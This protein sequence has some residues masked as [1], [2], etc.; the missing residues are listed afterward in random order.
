M[1]NRESETECG[2]SC[3]SSTPFLDPHG[4]IEQHKS[5][6][7]HWQQGEV[8]YFVTWRLADALPQEKLNELRDTKRTWLKH[9]P[10]PWN[11]ATEQEYH[12]LF[13]RQIDVW[14]DTGSGS[15]LLRDP[16]QAELVANTL[17]HFDN[18]RY[19]LVAFVVMP[20]HVH[21]LF[22]LIAPHRLETAIKSWKGFSAREI[23]RQSGR[24]G[25]LWQEDYWDRM[26]RNEEHF[27]MCRE[28]ILTNPENA[29]LRD[30]EFVRYDSET[31]NGHSCP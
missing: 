11:A 25:S 15:C 16:H 23:N 27:A 12:Q 21:V 10:E 5:R 24:S 7:P 18:E 3:P 19:I 31:E 4:K 29:R 26:I 17:R 14:L 2:H 8:F 22:R 9:N 20:N 30:G 6:L 1:S 13:S 28:Y